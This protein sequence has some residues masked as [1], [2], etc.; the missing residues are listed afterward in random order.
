MHSNTLFFAFVVLI[1]ATTSTASPQ[2]PINGQIGQPGQP[3]FNGAVTPINGQVGQPGQPGF[4]GVTTPINGQVGQPGFNGIPGQPGV[5]NGQTNNWNTGNPTADCQRQSTAANACIP[6]SNLMQMEQATV[7]SQFGNQY[8]TPQCQQTLRT[9]NTQ[10]TS[11]CTVANSGVM[12][13]LLPVLD[14]FH[15]LSCT[16]SGNTFCYLELYYNLARNNQNATILERNPESVDKRI[17]CTPCMEAMLPRFEA[18]TQTAQAIIASRQQE[19]L[20]FSSPSAPQIRRIC[21]YAAP[22]SASGDAGSG[23]YNAAPRAAAAGSLALAAAA[24]AAVA[25]LA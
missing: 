10:S 7:I 14:P 18:V 20:Q 22:R 12:G 23:M 24:V 19:R 17:L 4:N 15:E 25:M 3:G 21:G 5:V 11:V 2:T 8:C 6:P 1:A 13:P 16:K 9:I